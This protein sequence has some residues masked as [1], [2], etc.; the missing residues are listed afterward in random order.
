MPGIERRR[1]IRIRRSQLL[2]CKLADLDRP[3]IKIAE[4]FDEYC[5]AF[6]LVYQEYRASGYVN[7]DPR[8]LHYNA[9]SL[10]PTTSLFVFKSFL[11]VIAS[12]SLIRDSEL[13]GLPVDSL[14]HDEV[15]TLR[16]QGRVVAEIGALANTRARRWSNVV[17][18][19]FKALYYYAH[20]AKIDDL[21]VMVNP[22]HARFYRQ[23]LLFEPMGEARHYDKVGAPAI[24]LRLELDKFAD[25]LAEIYHDSDFET[26]L[27]AFFT[28][29]SDPMLGAVGHAAKGARRKLEPYSIFYF[30]R[31][32]PEILASASSD[33]KKFFNTIYHHEVFAASYAPGSWSVMEDDEVRENVRPVLERLH[34]ENREDYTDIAFSRNLGLIDYADQQ[35]LLATRVAIPGLGGVGGAHLTTLARTGVGAFTL[36]DFDT[37]SP[38]NI[39]R[40]YGSDL[41]SFTQ[42]KLK[43]MRDRALYINPFLD[44]RCF[45][46]G[47]T[48]D[49]LD[50]FLR[51]VDILVDSLDFFVQDIRRALFN[52]AL[53]LNI[54]VITAAPAGCSSSVLVFMPGGM[55][56]DAYF[57]VNDTTSAVDQLIR[58][59]LGIAPRPTHLRYMDRR[60]VNL[61]DRRVPSLDIGCELSAAMTATEVV[62]LVTTGKPSVAVPGSLQFDARRGLFRKSRLRWGVNTPWQ[63]LKIA[64]AGKFLLPGPRNSKALSTMPGT[65]PSGAMVPQEALRFVIRAAIQAPS[66]DN[67]QPWKFSLARDQVSLYVD[68]DA[69]RSFFNV[70]QAASL[71][72]AGAAVQNMEYAAGMLG[73]ETHITLFPDGEGSDR[74]ARVDLTATGTPFD[75]LMGSAMWRRCT[76]RRM[77]ARQP[78]P[79]VVWDRIGRIAD[80]DDSVLLLHCSSRTDLR[81]LARAVYLADRVRV[82]RR[83][84]HE[85]LMRVIRFEPLPS[86]IDELQCPAPFKTGLPLKNLQAGAAGGLYLRAVRPWWAMRLANKTGLG[87]AMP[88]Y[89]AMSVVLSGGVGLICTESFDELSLVRAGRAMERIWCALEQYGFALQPLAALPLLLLRLRLEGEAP[90]SPGHPE[91]LREAW[92]LASECLGVSPE[93]VPLFMFRTGKS[94]PIAQRTYRQDVLDLMV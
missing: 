24:P 73:L 89:G 6:R 4:E 60:F 87:R 64:L 69:D 50:E 30:L 48:P 67:V 5:K 26:D 81:R 52:R 27:H 62:R 61:H 17:I 7:E 93:A 21:V 70:R 63:R 2:N 86:E 92:D 85:Y 32:R 28:N 59:T 37:Y 56:Y 11:N 43:T 35:K 9:W 66:G 39:N 51:D 46:E 13:F 23:M 19:L 42:P 74:V 22:K 1:T 33:Q 38:V 3:S 83:D 25:R 18:L 12:L 84:L 78:V 16:R 47:V 49:N 20:L 31:N 57:G 68:R 77:Y 79:E 34:L 91:L 80:K 94:G 82:E 10:L 44:I 29:F 36:A 72:S 40:Q 53:A 14:Y 76:N 45:P 90:F 58:F 41:N 15:N 71:L 75:E 65:V 54:P 88:A 8:E 55:N